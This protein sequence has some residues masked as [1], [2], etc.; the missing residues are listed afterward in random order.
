MKSKENKVITVKCSDNGEGCKKEVY[1]KSIGEEGKAIEEGSIT[2]EDKAGN[3]KTC[4]VK[5]YVDRKKPTCKLKV[6]EVKTS[7][8]EGWSHPGVKVTIESKEDEGSGIL[9]YRYG[10]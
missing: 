9:H 5:A 6:E 8:K 2:I 1:S 4:P 10:S 3:K 7:K